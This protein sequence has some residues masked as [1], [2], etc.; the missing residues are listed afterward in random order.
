MHAE[1]TIQNPRF[2]YDQNYSAEETEKQRAKERDDKK[3]AVGV[4]IQFPRRKC[5][6]KQ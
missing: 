5:L 2:F 6:S 4:Q 1:Q 3:E